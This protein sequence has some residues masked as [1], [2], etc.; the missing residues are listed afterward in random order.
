VHDLFIAGG[1]SRWSSIISEP[2]V[3]EKGTY[4]LQEPGVSV[5]A[6]TKVEPEVLR[7]FLKGFPPEL[8]FE[9]YL[10]DSRAGGESALL[11]KIAGQLCYMSFDSNRTLNKDI[12]KYIDH[13]ESSGHGSVLEHGSITFLIYGISRSLTHEL[14]RHRIGFAFSQL[15]QR[16]VDGTKLRFVERPEFVKDEFFH[17]QFIDRI[18]QVSQYYDQLASYLLHRRAPVVGEK[19]TDARKAV[20]QVA[21]AVLP[22]ETEAPIIVTAN[23]RAWR[24]FLNMRGSAAAETEIRRVAV[25]LYRILSV[26]EP[27]IYQDFNVIT[28]PDDTIAL[29]CK[30]PKV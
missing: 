13:I 11:S 9:K 24:H 3:T 1:A 2:K 22:N 28:L 15:S 26:L 21:R 14:V 19:R 6:Q 18:D 23:H 12:G 25:Y 27:E 20:N 10:D 17:S 16:Y 30:Y 7:S 29:S 5:L 4:Y 8:E